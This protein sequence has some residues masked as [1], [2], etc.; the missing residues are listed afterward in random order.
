MKPASYPIELVRGDDYDLELTFKT[1]ASGAVIPLTGRSY[2]AQVRRLASDDALLAT[3][4]V[5]TARLA[6]GVVRL[7]LPRTITATLP[8]TAVWDCEETGTDAKVRTIL[9]GPVGALG[10]V[11]R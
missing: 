3:F 7:S 5:D 1:S 4:T 9:A 2:R 10:Q 6:D 11:T 8:R